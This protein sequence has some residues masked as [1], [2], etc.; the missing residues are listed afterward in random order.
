MGG[1]TKNKKTHYIRIDDVSFQH[2]G[3]GYCEIELVASV[4]EDEGMGYC[5]VV[6]GYPNVEMHKGPTTTFSSGCEVK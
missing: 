1:G 5:Q 4:K 6:Q 2:H 3:Q